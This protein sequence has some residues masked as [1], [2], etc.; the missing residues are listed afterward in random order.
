MEHEIRSTRECIRISG[1]FFFHF[2]DAVEL[3]YGHPD[4]AIHRARAWIHQTEE[5][6]GVE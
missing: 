1:T 5:M 3:I 2:G 6:R 4:P